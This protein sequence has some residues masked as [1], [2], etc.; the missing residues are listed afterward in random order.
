MQQIYSFDTQAQSGSSDA[1]GLNITHNSSDCEGPSG[2]VVLSTQPMCRQRLLSLTWASKVQV[3]P[4]ALFLSHS[5][6]LSLNFITIYH[7]LNLNEGPRPKN[8]GK[9][10]IIMFSVSVMIIVIILLVAVSFACCWNTP[11]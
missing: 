3:S 5:P 4:V 8:N 1:C 7:P 11:T 9:R 2:N 6:T 10:N